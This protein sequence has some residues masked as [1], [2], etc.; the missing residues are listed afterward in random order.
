MKPLT[1]EGLIKQKVSSGRPP[2][3]NAEEQSQALAQTLKE[4]RLLR[5]GLHWITTTFRQIVSKETLKR[6]LRA[7]GYT[8]KRRRRSRRSSRDEAAFRGATQTRA[9][10]RQYCALPKREFDLWYSDEAG[11][12]TIPSVPYAWQKVGECWELAA[13]HGPRQNVMGLW[14]LQQEFHSYAFTQSLDSDTIIYCLDEFA[15]NSSA[16]RWSYATRRP[17]IGARILPTA[18]KTERRTTCTLCTSRPL[19]RN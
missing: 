14:S 12:T 10:L 5:Q 6:W 15:V 7:A 13:A 18:W 1:Q 11:F 3:L 19:A 16:R 8:W 17:F 9:D 2:K 4:P